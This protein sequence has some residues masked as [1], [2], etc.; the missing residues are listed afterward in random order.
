MGLK[1]RCEMTWD[2]HRGRWR[3]VHKGKVYYFAPRPGDKASTYQAANAWWR[4]KRA[5]LGADRLTARLACSCGYGSLGGDL[6]PDLG[7][8]SFRISSG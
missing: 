2:L 3:K 8:V 6:A 7:S 5:E 1:G 4:A